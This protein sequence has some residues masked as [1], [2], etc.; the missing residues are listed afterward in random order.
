M[1]KLLATLIGAFFV[2]GVAS[3]QLI[4]NKADFTPVLDGNNQEWPQE[5][6]SKEDKTG[7]SY[8]AMADDEFLYILLVAEQM[9][10]QQKIMRN[11]LVL[12]FTTKTGKKKSTGKLL[13][14]YSATGEATI[15]VIRTEPG[16]RP[17]LEYM[18]ELFLLRNKVFLADGFVGKFKG[19]QTFDNSN[20]IN[21]GVNW[22]ESQHMVYE[23]KIP[24][25]QLFTDNGNPKDAAN[26]IEMEVV[27]NGVAGASMQG[28]GGGAM[29]GGAGGG[30][31]GGAGAGGG[32]RGGAGRPPGG[33]EGGAE[34]GAAGGGGANAGA[35]AQAVDM[36]NK[37]SFKTVLNFN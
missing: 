33:A 32:M 17:D 31:R 34:G 12:N 15:P 35:R 26:S 28:G 8:Q 24:L 10:F 20:G 7:L 6:L 23:Y 3:A 19:Q 37:T 25:N 5:K 2:S 13:Y 21:L 22:N 27:V 9:P 16:K 36:M 1:R 4:V 29:M 18:K 11:G 30:M 14:P